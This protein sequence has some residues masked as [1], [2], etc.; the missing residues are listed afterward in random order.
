MKGEAESDNSLEKS[1]LNPIDDILAALNILRIATNTSEFE[2]WLKTH[3]NKNMDRILAEGYKF[4]VVSTIRLIINL[5]ELDYS[6]GLEE[7][8]IFFRARFKGIPIEDIPNTSEKTVIIKNIWLLSRRLRKAKNWDEIRVS[9]TSLDPLIRLFEEL[10]RFAKP[11]IGID[12]DLA[13]NIA[14]KFYAFVYLNDVRSGVPLGYISPA[15]IGTNLSPKYLQLVFKG[16]VLTLQY[17]WSKLLGENDFRKSC[18]KDLHKIT[19]TNFESHEG[20]IGKLNKEWLILDSFFDKIRKEIIGPLENGLGLALGLE[21]LL[22]I[23]AIGKSILKPLLSKENLREPDYFRRKTVDDIKKWLDYNLLWY[24]VEVLSSTGSIFSGVPA[25]LSVLVGL[26]NLGRD[27]VLI[28]IFRHPEGGNMN[29]Y[30][31]GILIPA[32]GSI[33]ITDYS[34]WL[35]F[36]D[37]ATDYSGFGGNLY[38]QAKRYIDIFREKDLIE[39]EEVEIEINLFKEYLKDRSVSSVF[40]RVITESPFGKSVII[41]INQIENERR[42]FQENVKGL[43][44]ELMVYKW[45]QEQEYF[46]EVKHNYIADKEEIDVFSKK[47][48]KIYLYECK[49]AVHKDEIIKTLNQISR[50]ILVLRSEYPECSIIPILVTYFPLPAERTKFFEERGIKVIDGFNKKIENS[51]FFSK[52]RVKLVKQIF[53]S[54]NADTKLDCDA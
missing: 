37:S 27:K 23:E 2:S 7:D 6:L 25:F 43:L 4:F 41:D 46:E 31:Y 12:K 26:V 11:T 8:F 51:S 30:S 47:G 21:P 44:F 14:T 42:K 24:G 17:L 39:V 18:I 13:L 50:K 49:V 29:S 38:R 3:H 10:Y 28:R 36:F 40:D 22:V 33:G 32:Y 54:Q 9:I 20:D 19:N 16:Y 52:D 5:I 48:N 1:S 53:E 34:G 15:T 35:I 45:V